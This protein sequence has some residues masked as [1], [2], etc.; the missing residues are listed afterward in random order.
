MYDRYK[1]NYV[2][3]YQVCANFKLKVLRVTTANG[4]LNLQKHVFA[5]EL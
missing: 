1:K 3:N 4:E 2:S 5:D